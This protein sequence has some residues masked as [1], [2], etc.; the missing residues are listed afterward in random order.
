M[1]PSADF[2]NPESNGLDD[3][4]LINLADDIDNRDVESLGEALGFRRARVNRYSDTNEEGRQR[5]SKGTRQ[6]LFD[7][8]QKVEPEEQAEKLEE[9]LRHCNL[10]SLARR[11][12]RKPHTPAG[13]YQFK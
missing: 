6:M 9:T 1:M 5:T 8:R 4:F 12:F 3:S 13:M 11:H 2:L 7:W 10:V